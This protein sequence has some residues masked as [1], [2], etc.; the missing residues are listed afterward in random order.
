MRVVR[1]MHCKFSD[2]TFLLPKKKKKHCMITAWA[3]VDCY[4]RFTLIYAKC[5]RLREYVEENANKLLPLSRERLV[6]WVTFSFHRLCTCDDG[7]RHMKL[8][9]ILFDMGMPFGRSVTQCNNNMQNDCLLNC[10]SIFILHLPQCAR[11]T[12]L[13]S[14]LTFGAKCEK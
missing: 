5:F 4:H 12:F 13:T 11:H 9:A 10:L 8:N 3:V 6:S 2:L 1:R 7:P 14:S